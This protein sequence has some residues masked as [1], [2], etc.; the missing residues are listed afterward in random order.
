MPVIAVAGG[1]GPV[2]R[3]IVEALVIHGGHTVHVLSRTDR[4]LKDGV[5]FLKV[6]YS[7]VEAMSRALAESKIDIIICAIG[8]FSPESSQVQQNLILAAEKSITTNKFLVASFDMLHLREHIGLNPLARY[9]YE[10]LDLLEAETSLVHT[11]IACGWFADYYGV[12]HYPSHLHPWINVV[13]MAKCRAIV[14]GDGSGRADFITT[15]DMAAYVA[16]LMDLEQWQKVSNITGDTMSLNE[17]VHLAEETRGVKFDVAYDSL[18]KL[19]AGT[20]SF[21]EDFPPI[22]LEDGFGDEAFYALIHRQAGM[23]HFLV[24]REHTLND[25]F[26]DVK[27]KTVAEVMQQSWGGR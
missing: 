13:N 3:T 22:G 15:Q 19:K 23:N 17:L 7:D 9:T 2:G 24:P 26:P 25:E 11:R 27:R 6:D 18:E 12:P 5:K 16:R 8:V 14:P 10:A 20:I 1:S 21:F 4:P